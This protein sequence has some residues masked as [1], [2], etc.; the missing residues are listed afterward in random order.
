MKVS[1]THLTHTS[2]QMTQQYT[3]PK[4]LWESLD[5]VLHSKAIS[6][7]KEVSK[8]LGVPSN[9]LIAFLNIDERGKFTLIPDDD[10]CSYQ[11]TALIKHNATFMRCRAT[12]LDMTSKRCEKH[13]KSSIDVPISTSL[14]GVRRLITPSGTYMVKDELVFSLSGLQCG[15]YK[16]GKCTMFEIEDTM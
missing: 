8:E 10:N 1:V 6:L 12:T 13:D 4:R 15:H 5:A 9:Q 7:A 3:I 11:C 14:S 2:K 16:N